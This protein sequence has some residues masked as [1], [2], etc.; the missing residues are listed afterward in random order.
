M[1]E[2]SLGEVYIPQL[3]FCGILSMLLLEEKR[4]HLILHW[5]SHQLWITLKMSI[6]KIT[7]H[8]LFI[9]HS[10]HIL[11]MT[12]PTPRKINLISIIFISTLAP[13]GV[14]GG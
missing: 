6:P 10:F 7:N 13:R 3:Y 14:G 8:L 2:A 1:W 4:V 5:E 11:I 12:L 9:N